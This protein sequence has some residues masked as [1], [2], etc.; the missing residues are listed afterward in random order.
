MSSNFQTVNYLGTFNGADG[1]TTILD[2]S[3]YSHTVTNYG[4]NYCYLNTSDKK[5][6]TASLMVKHI[7]KTTEAGTDATQIVITNH[8]D[9][10]SVV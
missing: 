5:F 6:G 7:V 2:N 8:G 1:S 9:R 4:K 10:K 3:V